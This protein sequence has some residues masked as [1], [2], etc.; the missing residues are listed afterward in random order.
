MPSDDDPQYGFH[1]LT[2][3]AQVHHEPVKLR[4]D[5]SGGSS[6]RCKPLPRT[7]TSRGRDLYGTQQRE[8]YMGISGSTQ[9]ICPV[10]GKLSDRPSPVELVQIGVGFCVFLVH[11][12][13]RL[14]VPVGCRLM[15]VWDGLGSEPWRLTWRVLEAQDSYHRELLG[16]VARLSL[17]GAVTCKA[18]M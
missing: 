10:V 4:L 7:P 9:L 5:M 13:L 15:G 6:P 3:N 11:Y 12:T 18:F 16:R 14:Q 8:V 17:T 1:I 2:F